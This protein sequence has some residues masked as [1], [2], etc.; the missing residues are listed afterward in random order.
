MVLNFWKNNF[1]SPAYPGNPLPGIPPVDPTDPNYKTN[2][3]WPNNWGFPLFNPPGGQIK[4]NNF[5]TYP[6][7]G[8]DKVYLCTLGGCQYPNFT[9]INSSATETLI[10]ILRN[11][12]PVILPLLDV[13]NNETHFVVVTGWDS[14]QVTGSQ[15]G[16][17][18]VNDPGDINVHYLNQVWS[19]P[20]V[21]NL[22]QANFNQTS[23]TNSLNNIG[24]WKVYTNHAIAVNDPLTPQAL[25]IYTQDP[26]EFIL[27]DP[28]GRRT[29]F[30]PVSNTSYQEIPASEYANRV[31]SDVQNVSLYP[32]FKSLD[33]AVPMAGQYTLNVIGTGSGNFTVEV[34]ASDAAGNWI[35]QTYSGTTSPGVS[36]QFTFQGTVISFAA[37]AANLSITSASQ[38]FDVPGQFT[39]GSGGTI[40]PVTQPVTLQLGS[41]FLVTIPPGS[42]TDVRPGTGQFALQGR[43]INGVQIGGYVN[44][45][46]GNNYAFRFSGTASNLPSANPVDV[47]LTIGN[48][49]GDISVNATFN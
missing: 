42:F 41:G 45:T 40:S 32:P 36:S 14:Q 46:G 49:G 7:V 37:F 4:W 27:T 17:F 43:T 48:N 33:M 15:R 3:A 28:Q 16:D 12:V 22:N 20:A 21:Y 18:L 8:L 9:V 13:H 26:V 31:Y 39:L 23:V 1:T 2:N 30:D 5:K 35:T 25:G 47:R 38:A 24:K 34:D 10:N 19:R 44:W 6:E 11:N 29:G